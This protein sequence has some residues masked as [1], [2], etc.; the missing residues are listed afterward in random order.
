MAHTHPHGDPPRHAPH[1]GHGHH[2]GHDHH[3]G[4]HHGGGERAL[5]V[6]FL[7]NGGF[8]VCEA[9]AGFLT[10]SLALLS[11]AAHMV[12]D[13]AALAIA[14]VAMRL[15]RRPRSPRGTFGWR[16]A[17][18]LAA[19]VNAVALVVAC[20]FIV[21]EAI[22]RLRAGPPPIPGGWVLA[23]GFVGLAINLGSAFALWRSGGDSLN[24]RG[25][26]I[27]MLADALGSVGAIVAALC[28]LLFGWAAADPIASLFIAGLV[29]YGT[30]GL[31]RDST[32]VLLEFAPP[33]TDADAVAAV[34]CESPEVAAAHDVHVWSLASGEPIVTAHLVLEPGP[35]SRSL[36]AA[37]AI[38]RAAADALYA[39]FGVHHAT[40]QV[41]AQDERCGG[42][43]L[44]AS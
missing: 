25:A 27:H 28:T 42:C 15:A 6:A 36:D 10:G 14:L 30:W 5:W 11:D 32:A 1:R 4:H 41:D 23:V 35:A 31:L 2:H 19:F 38:R 3:H 39:R 34:L 37:A 17:E 22:T 20:V 44:E 16:R 13:V 24:I 7:L 21:G 18:V 9:V 43:G 26:L 40:L 8:L 29:L 12:S 33:G